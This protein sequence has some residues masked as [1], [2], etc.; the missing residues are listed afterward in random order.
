MEPAGALFSS[1]SINVGPGPPSGPMP[2]TMYAKPGA[3][4][5]AGVAP[6]AAAADDVDPGV[7]GAAVPVEVN[8]AAGIP[9]RCPARKPGTPTTSGTGSGAAEGAIALSASAI[10]S[11]RKAGALS[12]TDQ[13]VVPN[14]M[15][16]AS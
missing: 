1:R 8:T 7:T 4:V 13:K 9:P 10:M 14:G 12:R 11:G 2:P 16:N 3:G 6:A 15:K 5:A